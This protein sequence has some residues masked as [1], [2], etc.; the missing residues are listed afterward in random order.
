MHVLTASS[1]LPQW[2]FLLREKIK[3]LVSQLNWTQSLELQVGPALNKAGQIDKGVQTQAV[4]SVVG[5]VS[6]EDTDLE[7]KTDNRLC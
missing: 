4:I 3:V 5:Q 1:Y 6:H 7:G 2:V